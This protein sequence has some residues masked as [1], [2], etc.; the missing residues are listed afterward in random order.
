MLAYE[1]P[2]FLA[3]EKRRFKK[4]LLMNKRLP[5]PNDRPTRWPLY[6]VGV[7]AVI[8]AVAGLL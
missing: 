2:S 8:A 7:V 3:S 1:S 5:V 6:A 4:T